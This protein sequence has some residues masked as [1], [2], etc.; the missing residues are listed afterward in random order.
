VV[1]A[2]EITEIEVLAQNET[3]GLG[4]DAIEEIAAKIIEE[5]SLEVDSISGATNSSEGTINAV[6]NA[7]DNG[8]GSAAETDAT[9][10]S[11]SESDIDSSATWEEEADSET[12]NEAE[13]V[14][15]VNLPELDL[16]NGEYRGSAEGHRAAIEVSVL[17]EDNKI[18]EI[19]IV[20]QEESPGI[21][22]EA[23]SE[24]SQSLLAEQSLEVDLVSGATNSSE[25]FLKAVNNALTGQR[26]GSLE[27][28][29]DLE[30][31]QEILEAEGD[32]ESDTD[33]SATWEEESDSEETDEA[34]A[35]GGS[36]G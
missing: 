34:A 13:E 11:D 15:F 26:Y 22:D 36:N 35:E 23:M 24:L 8:S 6:K 21:G 31:A 33:S 10:E 27:E 17:V 20:S 32:S 1:E 19:R 2:G 25:G 5:Q 16:E 18:N 30:T 14:E 7:L 9:S 28:A 3:P 12:E 4:D 29:E